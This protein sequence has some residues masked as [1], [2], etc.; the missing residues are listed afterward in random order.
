[1]QRLISKAAYINLCDDDGKTPLHIAIENGN[2][3]IVQL[4][5]SERSNLSSCD[6][7]RETAQH[8]ARKGQWNH[9]ATLI[10]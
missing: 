5:L 2:E 4:L 10:K 9:F 3:S 6:M 1:M 8:K 7:N